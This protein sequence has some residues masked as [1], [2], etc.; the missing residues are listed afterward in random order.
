[1]QSVSHIATKADG[2]TTYKEESSMGHCG[3]FHGTKGAALRI[4]LTE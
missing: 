2:F 1:M 4:S 3:L